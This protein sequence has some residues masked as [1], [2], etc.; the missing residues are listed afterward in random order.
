MNVRSL[1]F[2]FSAGA[3]NAPRF[4]RSEHTT[5]C[6]ETFRGTRVR[7]IR[8]FLSSSLYFGPRSIFTLSPFSCSHVRMEARQKT[9]RADYAILSRSIVGGIGGRIDFPIRVF[10]RRR[11]GLQLVKKREVKIRGR[12]IV[13]HF[14]RTLGWVY[15]QSRF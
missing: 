13:S 12:Q 8:Y 1:F 15:D 7:P 9:L 14:R 6:S 11:Y 10:Q 4:N 2:W 3:K 5:T